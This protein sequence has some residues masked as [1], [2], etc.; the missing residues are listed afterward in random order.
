MY[1]YLPPLFSGSLSRSLSP[2]VS[3]SLALSLSLSV[4]LC[5]SL[6]PIHWMSIQCSS[7]ALCRSLSPSV[8]ICLC[9]SLY[10]SLS[11]YVSLYL[12]LSHSLDVYPIFLSGSLSLAV[13]LCLSLSLSVSLCLSL[14]ISLSPF[15]GCLSKF[16]L[17]LSVACWFSKYQCKSPLWFYLNL[18]QSLPPSPFVVLFPTGSLYL[19][20]TLPGSLSKSA[21][22][23]LSESLSIFPHQWFSGSGSISGSLSLWMSI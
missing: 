11:H 5:L 17:W 22:W 6:F 21:L 23:N 14:P 1:T 13:S 12:S 15:T 19:C 8:S 10:L 20:K 16:P 7:L 4:S 3:L 18:Y 9:L 2:S